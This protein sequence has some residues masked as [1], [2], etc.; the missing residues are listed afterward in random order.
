MMIPIVLSRFHSSVDFLSSYANV[1]KFYIIWSSVVVSF[2]DQMKH[3]SLFILF[4]WQRVSKFLSV[5]QEE[6]IKRDDISMQPPKYQ[7][8]EKAFV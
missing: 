5:A 6:A 7:T 2:P 3:L 1:Y 8:I 4:A